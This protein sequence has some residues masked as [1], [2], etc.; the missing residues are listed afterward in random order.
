[1]FIAG[2]LDIALSP[3]HLLSHLYVE[4]CIFSAVQ[5]M[6]IQYGLTLYVDFWVREFCLR[7]SFALSQ[8][9]THGLWWS[10]RPL[11]LLPID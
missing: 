2:L 9:H 4:F 7:H 5:G 6:L 11:C 8:H 1:M 3:L 10:A